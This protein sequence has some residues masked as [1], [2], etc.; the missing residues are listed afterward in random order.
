M[1]PIKFEIVLPEF[2]YIRRAYCGSSRKSQRKFLR[3]IWL[4]FN[5]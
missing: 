2:N 4:F 5:E 3:K 1:N